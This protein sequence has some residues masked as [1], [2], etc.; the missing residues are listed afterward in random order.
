MGIPMS[1]P[2]TGDAHAGMGEGSIVTPYEPDSCETGIRPGY[3]LVGTTA[4]DEISFAGTPTMAS[5]GLRSWE[6]T[7]CYRLV[8][9]FPAPR[10][11]ESYVS[12]EICITVDV[13]VPIITNVSVENHRF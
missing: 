3:E 2:T 12:E 1:A 5:G 7:Y 4:M 13:D 8:A 10:S 9:G 6:I 11:G